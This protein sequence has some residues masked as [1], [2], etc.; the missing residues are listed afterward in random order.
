MDRKNSRGNNEGKQSTQGQH[1]EVTQK[2]GWN[3]WT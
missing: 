2:K 1:D 3:N